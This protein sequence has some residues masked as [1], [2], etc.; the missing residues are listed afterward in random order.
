MH[1]HQPIGVWLS[2]SKHL[3]HIRTKGAVFQGMHLF[4]ASKTPLHPF[5]KSNI[6]WFKPK[7]GQK[8]EPT[9]YSNWTKDQNLGGA[10]MCHCPPQEI[11]PALTRQDSDSEWTPSWGSN[12]L[13]LIINTYTEGPFYI[14]KYNICLQVPFVLNLTSLI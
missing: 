8:V 4:L 3:V 14:S 12:H 6:W 5:S 1:P 13:E 11:L 2:L 7:T 10:L 9:L